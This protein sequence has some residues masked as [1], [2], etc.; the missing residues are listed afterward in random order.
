MQ[1]PVHAVVFDAFGTLCELET[2]RQPFVK[3]AR[4]CRRPRDVLYAVMTRP[5]GLR[6]AAA[7]FAPAFVGVEFLEAELALELDGIRLFP[8][9][10]ECL[11]TLNEAGVKIG[12]VSNLAE[13]Y[14][15]PLLRMLPFRVDCACSFALG[16]LKPDPRIFAWICTRMGV[17]PAGVVMVGDT[18]SVDYSG[19][20]SFGMRAIHLDRTGD[21]R[22]AVPTV[23]TLSKLAGM[24]GI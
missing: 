14:A 16:Y 7:E 13:P 5:L 9:A 3:L 21:S 1:R 18:F 15:E 20:T 6:A 17:A 24:L 4:A 12:I 8:D 10:R 11:M 23:R 22:H 2:K 19:A